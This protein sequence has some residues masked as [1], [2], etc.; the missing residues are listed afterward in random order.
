MAK[1]RGV[2]AKLA[3]LRS[4]RKEPVA[5]A[6]IDELKTFL[7]DPSNFVAADAAA[8]IGETHLKD[9][10]PDLVAAFDRFMIDPEDTDKLCRAKI[11]IVA[12]LNNLGYDQPEVY[13]RG[14]SHVQERSTYPEPHD[15]AGP[16]RAD[17]ALGLVRINYPNVVN[18]LVDLLFDDEKVTR[19]ACVQAL[20]GSGSVAAVP[21]LR[22]K[23]RAADKEP[24]VT[25]ECFS[26][27]LK[28]DP[29]SVPFVAR[30][31]HHG[32]EAIQ[33]GAA[34]ALGETRRAGAFEVLRDFSGRLRLGPLQ[35]A[36]LLAIAM[37]RVPAAVDYLLELVERKESAFAALSALAIH[38]H[39]DKI[40]ERV[41]AAV[42]QT[43]NPSLQT[44]FEEK[45]R[46]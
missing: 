10:T 25:C 23:A 20:E 39:T 24:E 30:F 29:E 7:A 43:K 5:A 19:V 14:V 27:L 8:I 33:E 26:A 45:F 31:L 6:V 1:L 32:N 15:S 3:R 18:I 40:R 36:V 12:A 16:L 37:L 46:K 2:E 44:R 42:A 28:L 17:S 35:E 34:L 4:I 13:L 21:L 9:L 22:F 38:R 11:A 41:A